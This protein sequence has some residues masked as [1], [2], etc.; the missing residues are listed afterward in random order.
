MPR[1]IRAHDPRKTTKVAP[2][3][4]E[5]KQMAHPRIWKTAIAL[6]EGNMSRITV[7]SYTSVT[8]INP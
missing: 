5:V 2:S 4:V 1:K 3:P 6:A 7:N 8:V